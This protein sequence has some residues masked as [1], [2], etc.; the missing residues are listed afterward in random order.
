MQRLEVNCEVRHIYIYMSLRSEGL[1]VKEFLTFH[2]TKFFIVLITEE[3]N[4]IPIK[5]LKTK[6]NLLYI[7]NQSVPRSKHFLPR[8]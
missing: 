2:T 1:R 3:F 4:F 8:L 5:L 6:C 7:R